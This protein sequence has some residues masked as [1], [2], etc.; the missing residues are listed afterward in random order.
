MGTR[1][2]SEGNSELISQ[3]FSS[4][5]GSFELPLGFYELIGIINKIN[6]WKKLRV[7]TDYVTLKT[8]FKKNFLKKLNES[9]FLTFLWR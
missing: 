1:R 2:A 6:G 3:K 8:N 7:F 9:L 4:G 5:C